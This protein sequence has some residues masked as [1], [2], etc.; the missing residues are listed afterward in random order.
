MS[1]NYLAEQ[2]V[3]RARE[4]LGAGK[5]VYVLLPD[6]EWLQI[7]AI[8]MVPGS[9]R[10]L[11]LKSAAGSD[12]VDTTHVESGSILGVRVRDRQ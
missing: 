9:F 12:H 4:G 11:E 7:T 3:A 5:P 6:L 10:L 8:G 1:D 2:F